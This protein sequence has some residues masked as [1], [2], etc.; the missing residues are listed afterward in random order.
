[1][2]AIFIVLRHAETV[3]DVFATTTYVVNV[4]C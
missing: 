4:F 2:E 3:K 1:M